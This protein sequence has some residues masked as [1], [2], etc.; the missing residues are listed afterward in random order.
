MIRFSI[1]VI[2]QNLENN[3]KPS[4]YICQTKAERKKQMKKVF[5]IGVYKSTMLKKRGTFKIFLKFNN[6]NI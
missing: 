4:A 5:D 6:I 3:R 1:S 2:Y